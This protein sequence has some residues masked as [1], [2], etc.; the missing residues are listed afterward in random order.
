MLVSYKNMNVIYYPFMRC[1]N[2]ETKLKNTI[3]TIIKKNRDTNL[4]L[5]P[6]FKR[7]LPS[8]SAVD[9]T[10]ISSRKLV[11]FSR[12]PVSDNG[13]Q[14]LTFPMFRSVSYNS[15]LL[16]STSDLQLK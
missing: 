5:K 4:S 7:N 6:K 9:M 3:K 12:F 13:L 10:T 8:I 15:F 16:F 11:N 2:E 1:F 14:F